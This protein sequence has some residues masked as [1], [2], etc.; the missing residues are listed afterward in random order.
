MNMN[1]DMNM[2]MKLEDNKDMSKDMSKD[3][4]TITINSKILESFNPNEGI[5]EYLQEKLEHETIIV[6]HYT[7]TIDTDTFVIE[8]YVSHGSGIIDNGDLEAYVKSVDYTSNSNK[9]MA[10][11]YPYQATVNLKFINESN[12]KN[13]SEVVI[14]FHEYNTISIVED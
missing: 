14:F 9:K 8:P 2:N 12:D 11:D 10:K 3:K 1:M 5:L 6:R 7:D 4:V 13:N